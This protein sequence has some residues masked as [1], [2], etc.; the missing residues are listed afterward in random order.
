MSE[1]LTQDILYL[2]NHLKGLTLFLKNDN[3][4]YTRNN[5]LTNKH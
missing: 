2:I 1:T 5:T 4:Q 3:C